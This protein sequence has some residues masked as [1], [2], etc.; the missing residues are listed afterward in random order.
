MKTKNENVAADSTQYLTSTK[1]KFVIRMILSLLAGAVIG[2][3]AALCIDIF[4]EGTTE[5]TKAILQKIPFIQLY[6]FPWLML[7][8]TVICIIINEHF[9]K[10][11]QLQIDSWDGEDDEHINLADL[12]LNKTSLVSNIQVVGVQIFFAITTYSLMENLQSAIDSAMILITVVIYFIGLISSIFQQNHLIRLIKEYSPEKKGIIYDKNFHDVWL[13]S[14][15]EAEQHMIYQASYKTFR[16]MNSVF[17]ICL[18][19]AIVA[20]MFFPIGILCAIMTGLLW[21]IMALYYSKE[22]IKLEN[23]R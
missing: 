7:A 18:T 8:F 6:I 19:T 4:K 1:K 5:T 14:C 11:S 21:L 23:K 9:M 2:F 10:K 22:C 12:Y 17:S 20:G 13:A 15:D 16:F 3:L